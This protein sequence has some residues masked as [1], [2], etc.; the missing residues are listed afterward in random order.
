MRKWAQTG[1]L[2]TLAIILLGGRMPGEEPDELARLRK[3]APY[4]QS[5][6][7]REGK[8]FRPGAD[9]PYTGW[10]NVKH[11]NE[12]LAL[13]HFKEGVL[14]G[15]STT[16]YLGGQKRSEHTYH[17]GKLSGLSTNWFENGQKMQQGNYR[18]G[19]LE[20]LW[21]FWDQQGN[22]LERTIYKDGKSVER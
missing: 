20:G 15:T 21:I 4:L 22:E 18:M 16:W 9:A 12:G 3:K 1:L 10:V 8:I 2:A 5:F 14:H 7:Q 6:A 13:C 17:K 19:K 11:G